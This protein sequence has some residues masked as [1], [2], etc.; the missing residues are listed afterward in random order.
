MYNVE[1]AL[2]ECMLKLALFPCM[3]VWHLLAEY[4][5]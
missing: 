2:I 3:L 4:A 5:G 1:R